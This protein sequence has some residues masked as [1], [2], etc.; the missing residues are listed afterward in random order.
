MRDGIAS[1][2]VAADKA[3][4]YARSAQLNAAT[5][6]GPFARRSSRIRR[7]AAISQGFQA[8]AIPRSAGSLGGRGACR[9]VGVPGGGAG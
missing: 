9:G 6:A 5:L 2:R 8:R 1:L 3:L 7:W 4:A